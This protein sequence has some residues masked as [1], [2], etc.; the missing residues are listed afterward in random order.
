[1]LRP[2]DEL[3]VLRSSSYEDE[4]TVNVRG[5]VRNPHTILH[6]PTMDLKT[7]LVLSGGLRDEASRIIEIYRSTAEANEPISTH[8]VR[9]DQNYASVEGV[10]LLQAGD[11]VVVRE[12]SAHEDIAVI[13]VIGEVQNPGD[14]ALVSDNENISSIIN[15]AGGLTHEA[16]TNSSYVRR[17]RDPLVPFSN[18]EYYQLALDNESSSL[19]S[20]ILKKGDIIVIPKRTNEVLI[21]LFGTRVY[22]RNTNQLK[23]SSINILAVPFVEGKHAKWY[24]DNFAGGLANDAERKSIIVTHASGATQTFTGGLFKKYPKP[25]R[26]STISVSVKLKKD[27]KDSNS[28]GQFP[29]LRKGVILNIGDDGKIE[30]ELDPNN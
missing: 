5:A 2:W 30:E 22:E 19:S 6:S 14:Y 3:I 8:K 7:A 15:R 17:L 12:R 27:S 21:D 25:K 13:T 1:M 4:S 11:E 10:F 9:V 16:A 26:G 20:I 24:F 29:N 18:K 28:S 23:D